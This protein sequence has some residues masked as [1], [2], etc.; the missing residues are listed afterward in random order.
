VTV[1]ER[2]VARVTHWLGRGS[3]RRGF[4]VNTAVIGSA[5]AVNPLR[6]LLKPGTAY[7][8]LCGPDAGC[9]S[10]WTAMC[11]SVNGGM[12]TCPPGTM[13]AGWWK[14]DNSG[15]C[16]GAA[17]YY[18][19]CNITCGPC[20]CGGNG[21]C[22]GTGCVSC[23]CHCATG[24]CDE[25][26]VCCTEFRYGQC[27]Q[28]VACLGPIICRVVTC[29][30]PW[31]FDASCTTTAATSQ[32]TALHDAPCLH[33]EEAS[34]FGFGTAAAMGSP[35]GALRAPIVGID[36]TPT[37]KGYW[38][39]A[40]DGGIFCFGDARFHGSTGAIRLNERI[41]GIASTRTGAG[42][43]LVA[44]DGGIFCFGDARFHG[45][46]GAM[47]LREP[48]VGIAATATGDGYWLVAADG[49]IFSFG[50][51][52]FFGSTGALRLNRPIVGM[53]P[54]RRGHGY[55]LVASDGGIFAFGN[56]KFHGSTGDIALNQPIVDMAATPDDRGYWMLAGDGGVFCFGDAPYHGGLRDGHAPPGAAVEI[57][58]HPDGDGYWIAQD[59]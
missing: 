1:A 34:V 9:N 30:P 12:N 44:A 41:V 3:T 51:A 55:W 27:N 10:G 21:V 36:A 38:L 49:G 53:A 57:A 22:S 14:A 5:L 52:R 50:D 26:H 7:A 56:A 31:Q 24:T 6:F 25:R 11:C 23:G 54:S 59:N 20:G 42:Y 17:R 18:I 48:I 16:N 15:F 29:V 43:W 33:Y 47:R 46:T 37:G 58:A 39:V 32:A 45:S 13:P 2:V 4:L 19:D 35:H 40:S 8:A 28:D